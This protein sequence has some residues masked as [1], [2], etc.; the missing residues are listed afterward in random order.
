LS[1]LLLSGLLYRVAVVGL[2]LLELLSL[3]LLYRYQEF[4]LVPLSG[5]LLSFQTLCG[6]SFWEAVISG[7]SV[8]PQRN[9]SIQ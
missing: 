3:G 6:P 7:L 8:L 4:I 1:G 5:A 9:W 2:L